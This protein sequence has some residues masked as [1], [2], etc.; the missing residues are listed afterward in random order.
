MAITVSEGE[1]ENAAVT[2]TES[3][4]LQAESFLF[5]P[6]IST[7]PQ[8]V[9]P[10]TDITA[11]DCVVTRWSPW[12]ACSA[13]CGR[14]FKSKIRKIKVTVLC[15]CKFALIKICYSSETTF[16][17]LQTFSSPYTPPCTP[18]CSSFPP[19]HHH[20]SSSP[21]ICNLLNFLLYSHLLPLISPLSSSFL[22]LRFIA[23]IFLLL[24]LYSFCI[25]I[26]ISSSLSSFVFIIFSSSTS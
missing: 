20:S 2:T 26:L 24:L 6:N 3:P 9:D 15:P 19:H 21:F 8:I 13:T 12:S 10:E 23:V 11:V 14:G 1:E 7:H 18:F 22:F 16:F 4:A 5:G 17:T 25:I